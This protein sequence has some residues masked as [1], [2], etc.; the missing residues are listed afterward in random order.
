MEKIAHTKVAELL[1]NAAAVTR[2]VAAQRDDALQKVAAYE[3]DAR[4]RHIAADMQSKGLES[5]LDYEEKVAHLKQAFTNGQLDAMEQAVRMSA[6]QGFGLAKVA[7]QGNLQGGE[8]ADIPTDGA[9][10][11]VMHILGE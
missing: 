11:L 9:H 2:Y 1:R 10:P 6:T 7:S 5:E 8:G 4:C 3:L